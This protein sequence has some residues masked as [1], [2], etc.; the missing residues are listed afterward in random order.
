MFHQLFEYPNIGINWQTQISNEKQQ[1]DN[2]VANLRSGKPSILV[3]GNSTNGYHATVAY[4]LS[5]VNG[6]QTYQ[7][8]LYDPN[9]PKAIPSAVYADYTP[10]TNSFTYSFA[11]YYKGIIDNIDHF[12]IN[13]PNLISSSW[14]GYWIWWP[15]SDWTYYQPTGYTI[16]IAKAPLIVSSN[17]LTDFFSDSSSRSD[18]TKFVCG[19]PGSSGIEEAGI[20]VYAIPSHL[21][22][23]V[24][25]PTND[26]STIMIESVNNETGQL[27]GQGF[28][29]NLEAPPGI[30][31]YTIEPS[32][33]G[34]LL[35][36]SSA[37]NANITF[38]SATEQDH[39]VFQASNL[40][41]EASQTA[42][43]TIT[44]WQ[45][46]NNTHPV[47]LQISSVNQPTVIT[48]Y[49]PAN[50][51]QNSS[52]S[53]QSTLLGLS[54]MQISILVTTIAIVLVVCVAVIFVYTRRKTPKSQKT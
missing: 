45:S 9:F 37:L 7:I 29:V 42:N 2:L 39:A 51:Q 17:G 22:Y 44:D 40:P 41:I 12:G 8:E 47:T 38:F 19:I 49:N 35:S 31:N 10:A 54:T 32:N 15:W 25:D 1:I 48:T 4:A 11:S 20:Q 34:L 14:H 52:Q 46:L 5:M 23:K 21:P 24:I 53:G 26:E 30:F 33:I 36:T 27:V 50:E 18:S 6:G 3:L 43:F 13:L 16:I 28:L